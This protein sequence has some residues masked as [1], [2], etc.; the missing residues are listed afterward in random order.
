[1]ITESRGFQVEGKETKKYSARELKGEQELTDYF[2]IMIKNNDNINRD[3]QQDLSLAKT[4]AREAVHNKHLHLF[5]A[6]E[7][8]KMV[9]IG[10]LGIIDRKGE[11]YGYLSTLEVE[12]RYRGQ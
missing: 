1:M 9:G 3:E 8:D 2:F 4:L 10:Q 12:P 6:Y 11:R 5:G 7:A